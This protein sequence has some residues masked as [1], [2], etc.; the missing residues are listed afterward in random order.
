MFSHMMVGSN[1]LDR[2]KRFYDALFGAVGGDPG[3]IDDKG[4]LVYLQDGGVFLVTKPIDG[5]A[6]TAGNGCTASTTQLLTVNPLPTVTYTSSIDTVCTADAA[7]TLAGGAP[8][9]GAYTGPGVT[10]STF[11]PSTAGNGSHTITYTYT[12]NNSCSATASHVIV[13]DPCTGLFEQAS[14]NT[15]LFPNPFTT[16]LTIVRTNGD[17]ATVEVF[18]AQG[19]L[20]LSKS[21]TGTR[22]EVETSGLADGMYSIRITGTNGVET[23]RVMKGK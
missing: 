7:F 4:R 11:S 16:A 14:G 5:A 20:V 18:D 12:D 3:V 22:A 13:V 2:S 9:G 23:F 17:A 15:S 8:A 19:K 6:A 21:I 1:D 10:G